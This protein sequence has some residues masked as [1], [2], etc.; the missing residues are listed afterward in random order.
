MQW[1]CESRL[2]GPLASSILRSTSRAAAAR[3]VKSPGVFSGLPSTRTAIAGSGAAPRRGAS[4]GIYR[5]R[6]RIVASPQLNRHTS[7]Q[8]GIQG[9]ETSQNTVLACAAPTPRIH[10]RGVQSV[11]CLT[12]RGYES[13]MDHNIACRAPL[14]VTVTRASVVETRVA[15]GIAL[16]PRLVSGAVSPIRERRAATLGCRSRASP[17]SVHFG[18]REFSCGPEPPA[19]CPRRSAAW[20]GGGWRARVPAPL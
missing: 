19:A 8:V 17:G 6:H 9:H 15:I 5:Y 1:R 10:Y 16:S 12:C 3:A 18:L 2:Q 7:S 13:R 11:E 14:R 20:R 4:C